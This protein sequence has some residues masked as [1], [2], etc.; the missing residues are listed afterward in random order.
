MPPKKKAQK[1]NG[2]MVFMLDM[3][4]RLEADGHKFPRGLLDV[5]P[6]CSPLWNVWLIFFISS[7]ISISRLFNFYYVCRT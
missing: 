6:V 3:K 1:A 4:P 2:F 5:H 7:K